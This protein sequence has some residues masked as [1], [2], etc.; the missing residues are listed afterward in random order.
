[1]ITSEQIAWVAGILD[2]RGYLGK[3][4]SGELELPT[5]AVTMKAPSPVIERLCELTMVRPIN[6]GKNY[7][8]HGCAA[9]CPQPHVHVIGEYQRWIVT[10]AKCRV[11][12]EQCLPHLVALREEATVCLE[13]TQGQPYKPAT[14]VKMAD[15]QRTG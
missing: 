9:H 1:M 7:N 10:G 6:V 13:E 3:R 4:R 14:M 12:L 5:I 2:A 8:R 11:V 15:W